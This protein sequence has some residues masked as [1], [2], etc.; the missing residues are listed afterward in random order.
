MEYDEGKLMDL[1]KK[2]AAKDGDFNCAA[3]VSQSLSAFQRSVMFD[4]KWAILQFLLR[5][6]ERVQVTSPQLGPLMEIERQEGGVMRTKRTLPFTNTSSVELSSCTSET[7]TMFKAHKAGVLQKEQILLKDLVAV[8]QGQDG[9][10]LRFD[11][12]LRSFKVVDSTCPPSLCS[13][14]EDVGQL[15]HLYTKLQRNLD[16]IR[17]DCGLVAQGFKTGVSVELREYLKKIAL[18]EAMLPQM[19]L[20]KATVWLWSSRKQLGLLTELSNLARDNVGSSLLDRV[21]E[22][23]Q[24]GCPIIKDIALKIL[25]AMTKPYLSA[26]AQWIFKGRLTDPFNELFIIERSDGNALDTSR[27]PTSFIPVDLANRIT[28]TG[29]TLSFLD[30]QN[31]GPSDNEMMDEVPQLDEDL[32]DIASIE[33]YLCQINQVACT[34]LEAMIF[35]RHNL[36][37]HLKIIK[38]FLLLG[39]SDF[40]E[41]LLDALQDSLDRPAI[42]LFRHN[43]VGALDTSV[44][45]CSGHPLSDLIVSH[46]DVRL[47]EPTPNSNQLGWDIFT[48]DYKIP[49]ALDSILSPET[50]REYTKLSQFLWL[51]RRI[52]F[53]GRKAQS[54]MK[55]A[56]RMPTELYHDRKLLQ[57]LLHEVVE[58][59]SMLEQFSASTLC[60]VWTMFETTLTST[61]ASDLDTYISI[62]RGFMNDLKALLPNCYSSTIRT[63]LMSLFTSVLRIDKTV[64]MFL[65]YVG[66]LQQSPLPDASHLKMLTELRGSILASAKQFHFDMDQLGAVMDRES[67]ITA[68]VTETKTSIAVLSMLIDFSG[69][70]RRRAQFDSLKYAL[71]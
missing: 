3:K 17:P 52:L 12:R 63:R 5:L 4:R 31:Y 49:P 35:R 62:H 11:E 50:M 27:I 16:Y 6:A 69:Y 25:K 23:K 30:Q 14:V 19:T 29:K 28:N 64:Q 37:T 68:S 43:L 22:Y 51:E 67:M 47:H 33:S 53:T 24:H 32:L 8:L 71:K 54:A 60:R 36:M 40:S 1:L 65:V 66:H 13:L 41:T 10:L 70:H 45:S 61:P 59:L 21:S 15:G 20:K 48:L 26:L 18:F 42:G 58:S 7:W 9:Q 56:L 34:R 38:D 39:R 46:L 2:M 55:Q 44:R 57:M